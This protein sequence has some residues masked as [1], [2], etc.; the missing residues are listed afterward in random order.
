MK[1]DSK[2]EVLLDEMKTLSKSEMESYLITLNSY[3][4]LNL[5]NTK[6]EED[7][8][9]IYLDSKSKQSEIRIRMS[10]YCGLI[11][12]FLEAEWYEFINQL[13]NIIKMELKRFYNHLNYICYLEIEEMGVYIEN[14]FRV[15]LSGDELT[16][17]LAV[18]LQEITIDLY[19]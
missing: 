5:I 4:K 3:T 10:Y 2:I 18:E 13:K 15:I 6:D 16:S 9:D 11:N 17:E 12:W 7:Y 8:S 14:L 19:K 1:K